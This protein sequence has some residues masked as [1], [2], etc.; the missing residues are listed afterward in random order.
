MQL[1]QRGTPPWRRRTTPP[2]KTSLF[3]D[4]LSSPVDATRARATLL[5]ARAPQVSPRVRA[6]WRELVVDPTETMEAFRAL[7]CHVFRECQPRSNYR[8]DELLSHSHGSNQGV[9]A[10]VVLELE[11]LCAVYRRRIS[12]Q[13][14]ICKCI[15]EWWHRP[16]RRLDG[17]LGPAPALQIHLKSLCELGMLTDGDGDESVCEKK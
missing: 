2:A 5:G 10:T 1:L 7:Q 13:F 8:V 3:K 12:A 11:R 14:F 16:T 17:T 6:L 9:K 4:L 15:Y